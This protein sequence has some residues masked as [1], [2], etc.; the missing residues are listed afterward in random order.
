[1]N[2]PLP[3]S[4][5]GP[6][7]PF[8][9]VAPWFRAREKAEC[10][11]PQSYEE[12]T[13]WSRDVR[14][15]GL[16]GLILERATALKVELPDEIAQYLKADSSHVVASNLHLEHE[17]ARL[18]AAFDRD[19][20]PVMLL[21]GAALQRTIYDHP[22]LRPMADLDLLVRPPDVERTA[23]ALSRL[24]ARRGAALIRDDFFPRF[25][26]ETEWLIEGPRPVR[27]DLHARPFRPLRIARFMPDDAFWSDA[28][29]IR[30]G[31][32][33]AFL[34]R[35]ES[36]LIHLASHAAYHGCPRLLWLH[37]IH[38]YLRQFEPVLDM[39]LIARRCREWRLSFAVLT[40]LRRTEEVLGSCGAGALMERLS[41]HPVNWRDRWTVAHAP[42]DAAHPLRHVL[43]NLV[44]TP[45]TAFR[46]GYLRALLTPN[47][48]HLG[49]VYPYRHRGWPVM[50]NLWR[51]MRTV[52]RALRPPIRK[53]T[54]RP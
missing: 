14:R 23:A 49:E 22:A 7:D 2:E 47:R 46:F 31:G 53:P 1:M 18:V 16:S 38:R 42:H 51:S 19:R 40:A 44:C 26:Y 54:A 6:H 21:K 20:I 45:G 8:I 39:E 41:G 48:A 11:L 15:M 17:L 37:D 32:G 43:V 28:A 25:H 9:T 50:A 5:I 13:E 27:I 3:H 4:L 10:S 34:P 33:T 52:G 12:W 29:A 36:M 24:G 35:P 30:V